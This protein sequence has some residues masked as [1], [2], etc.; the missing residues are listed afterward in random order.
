MKA[1]ITTTLVALALTLAAPVAQAR[2]VVSH[3]SSTP[4]VQTAKKGEKAGKHKK[5]AKKK[6]AKQL[7]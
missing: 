6:A 1:L 4:Q 2:T 7:G 5:H 3:D